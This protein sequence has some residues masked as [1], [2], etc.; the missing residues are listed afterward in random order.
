MTP[1]R[2]GF[3]R[4]MIL[5]AIIATGLIVEITSAAAS[6]DDIAIN[7]TYTGTSDG[8]WAKTNE[9]FRDETTVTSTWSVSTSCTTAFDC[10]GEMSSDAGWN[11]PIRYVSGM[12]FVTRTIDN[13]ERCAD[14]ST[15]PG[16][17]TYK[18]Y[19][20]PAEPTRL[21]GWDTTVGISGACG[22]N[23]PLVVDMPFRLVPAPQASVEPRIRSG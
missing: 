15:G 18:V 6:F 10:V 17:Q 3:A 22:I 11:A 5:T 2:A 21:I 23:L 16:A 9:V 4:V 1:Q 20:D 19:Q 14:G 13:W 8:Q 7:G 12:W